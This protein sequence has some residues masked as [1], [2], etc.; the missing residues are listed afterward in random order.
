MLT[1]TMQ[2]VRFSEKIR[3][4]EMGCALSIRGYLYLKGRQKKRHN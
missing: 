4:R 2:E 1:E 3:D